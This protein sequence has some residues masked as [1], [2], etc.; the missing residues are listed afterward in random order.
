MAD[1][2]RFAVID[3]L[4]R[5]TSPPN[6]WHFLFHL[7]QAVIRSLIPCFGRV[8]LAFLF[9]LP[10]FCHGNLTNARRR[11]VV[12][13]ALAVVVVASSSIPCLVK[14]SLE[15]YARCK[16]EVLL[17]TDKARKASQSQHMSPIGSYRGNDPSLPCPSRVG[18]SAVSMVH[19]GIA[20][21]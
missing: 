16:P 11:A 7:M 20:A 21:Y 3:N 13:V 14:E 17:L 6:R 9:L 19:N 5:N 10:R 4:Q 8:G 12:L 18:C 2:I 15:R 1:L